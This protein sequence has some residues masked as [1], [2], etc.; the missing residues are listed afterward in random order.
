MVLNCE[1]I[2][3]QGVIGLQIEFVKFWKYMTL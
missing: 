2:R 1:T 3:V